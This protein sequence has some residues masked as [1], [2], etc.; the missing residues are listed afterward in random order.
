LA[1][2]NLWYQQAESEKKR[3]KDTVYQNIGADNLNIYGQ[4]ILDNSEN[5]NALADASAIMKAYS[6]SDEEGDYLL[7]LNGWQRQTNADGQNI[8][9]SPNGKMKFEASDDGIRNVMTDIQNRL[10]NDI[11]A[12]YT[13]GGDATST[14]QYAIKTI[15]QQPGIDKIFGSYGN[16]VGQYND[17]LNGVVSAGNGKFV[18]RFSKAQKLRHL[19][20]RGLRG[21]TID[22]IISQQE[23]QYLTPLFDSM[24]KKVGGEVI[25]GNDVATT[26]V[27]FGSYEMPIAA[28]A[29]KLAEEDTVMFEWDKYCQE[30][31]YNNAL[32]AYKMAKAKAE[33]ENAAGMGEEGE[34]PLLTK[35]EY[36]YYTRIYGAAFTKLPK[37]TAAKIKD[38][39]Q[40]VKDVGFGEGIL[41]E[42]KNK[43]FSVNGSLDDLKNLA[44]EESQ[45][46]KSLGLETISSKGYFNT[47]YR[48]KKAEEEEKLYSGKKGK[49]LRNMDEGMKNI[50]KGVKSRNIFEL[51]GA[52]SNSQR[53]NASALSYLMQKNNE[54][55]SRQK[56]EKSQKTLNKRGK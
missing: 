10:K 15:L 9:I 3:F 25:F 44:A 49:A 7:S 27:R 13:L 17:F 40:L 52:G 31:Q 36:S 30:V 41:K 26:K 34:Q 16:T 39:E 47:L 51:M 19:L 35:D 14:E 38:A 56:K 45:I 33:A 21:A 20:S 5:L 22:G 1:Q 23:I 43:Q 32:K 46:Y 48:K 18:P 4:A 28:Y 50:E 24:I 53:I 37:A 54:E 29:Q 8:L 12:S 55:D 42:E 6:R 11:A 2:Q